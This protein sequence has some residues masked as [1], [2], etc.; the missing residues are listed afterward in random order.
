MS[1]AVTSASFHHACPAA[2]RERTQSSIER[3]VAALQ[4][5]TCL[6]AADGPR[7]RGRLR[8]AMIATSF[9]P[10]REPVVVEEPAPAL[11][12][13]VQQLRSATSRLVRPP[14]PP[15]PAL[16]PRLELLRMRASRQYLIDPRTS[17]FASYWDAVTTIAIFFVALVTPYEV[18]FL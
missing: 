18:C 4:P 15:P 17:R 7:L 12:K 1:A 6:D 5:A 13:K 9:D 8:A 2:Q 16:N 3:A 14:P 10:K 11:W